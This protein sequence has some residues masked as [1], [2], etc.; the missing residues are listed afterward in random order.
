MNPKKILPAM[1]TI[2]LNL[3]VLF[4]SSLLGCSG[5]ETPIQHGGVLRAIPSLS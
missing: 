5:L 3:T 4:T 2:S 1:K